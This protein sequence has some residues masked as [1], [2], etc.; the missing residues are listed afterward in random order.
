MKV[1]VTA[2]LT[3]SESKREFLCNILRVSSCVYTTIRVYACVSKCA[4]K[5]SC[6][7]EK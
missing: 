1:C 5:R 6:E 2:K 3:L 4:Y 7:C